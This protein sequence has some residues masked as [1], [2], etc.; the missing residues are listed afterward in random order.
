MTDRDMYYNSY[1]YGGFTPLNNYPEQM[2]PMMNMPMTTQTP[3]QLTNQMPT[4]TYANSQL[5]DMNERINRL[6]RQVKRLDQRLNRLET[7][8]AN[9]NNYNQEP[10]N[11][12]YMM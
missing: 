7:P 3:T 5:N 6:E 1:G 12:M 11:N 2:P 8:Y 10:D 9:V 4:N